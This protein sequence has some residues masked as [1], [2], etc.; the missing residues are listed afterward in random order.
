MVPK[1]AASFAGTLGANKDCVPKAFCG[2]T[3]HTG[4]QT[5]NGKPAVGLP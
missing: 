3:D 5:G 2:T 4:S 1:A